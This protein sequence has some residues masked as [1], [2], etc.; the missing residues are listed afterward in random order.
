MFL[1]E[2]RK[3]TK[4]TQPRVYTWSEK[5]NALICKLYA[6]GAKI[7]WIAQ[8]LCRTIPQT[9]RQLDR[10]IEKKPGMRRIKLKKRIAPLMP[11]VEGLLP[12]NR[13]ECAWIHGDGAHRKLCRRPRYGLR[14]YCVAHCAIAY[15]P[16]EGDLDGELA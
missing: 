1:L 12:D 13:F 15:L 2:R 3:V 8:R 16:A 7:A 9:Q 10:L 4:P 5:D 6:A 11:Y 14:P